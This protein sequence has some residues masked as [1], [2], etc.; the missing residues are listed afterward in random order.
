M[1]TC[2]KFLFLNW[3]SEEY[4]ASGM[5]ICLDTRGF[6]HL[7]IEF[8]IITVKVQTIFVLQLCLADMPLHFFNILKWCIFSIISAGFI[9]C[10]VSSCSLLLIMAVKGKRISL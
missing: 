7:F 4:Q 1:D 10:V 5:R 2:W 6:I 3:V 8:H 9:W